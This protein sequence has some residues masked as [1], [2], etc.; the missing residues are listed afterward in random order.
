MLVE[1]SNTFK[2]KKLEFLLIIPKK[3]SLNVNNFPA[4]FVLE[5]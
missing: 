5:V 4:Y 2:I 1:L 3:N